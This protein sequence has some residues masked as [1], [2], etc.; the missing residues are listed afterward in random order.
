MIKLAILA[1]L[2]YIAYRLFSEKPQIGEGRQKNLRN[3][4]P[5]DEDFA[6]YEEID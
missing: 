4:E 1:F 5:D 6:D 2:L 3:Q